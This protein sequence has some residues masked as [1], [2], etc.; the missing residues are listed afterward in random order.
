MKK[1]KRNRTVSNVVKEIADNKVVVREVI[2]LK[3][4][5][6]AASVQADYF[7]ER[8]KM[9]SQQI[10]SGK[11]LES[12]DGCPKS[13]DFLKAEYFNN[14]YKAKQK[15]REAYFAKRELMDK[16]KLTED[17]VI[18]FVTEYFNGPTKEETPPNE[19]EETKK[20]LKK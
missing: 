13:E 16:H 10:E 3:H 14:K 12:V 5:F 2:R 20:I 8:A 7:F 9:I 11:I 17:E 19:E 4:E 6:V 1:I 18:G 15:F